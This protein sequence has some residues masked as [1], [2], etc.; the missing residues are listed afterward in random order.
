MKKEKTILAAITSSGVAAPD[1]IGKD[2][3]TGQTDTGE[4]DED[5]EAECRPY[6]FEKERMQKT[7]KKENIEKAELEVEF[8]EEDLGQGDQFMAVRQQ[9]KAPDGYKPSKGT[10]EPPK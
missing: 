9:Y 7:V 3:G 8:E 10:P 1:E 5:L 6:S 2:F 4:Y